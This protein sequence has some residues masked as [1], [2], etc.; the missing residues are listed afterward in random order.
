MGRWWV[1]WLRLHAQRIG[2]AT[3]VATLVAALVTGVLGGLRLLHARNLERRLVRAQ[4]LQNAVLE[5]QLAVARGGAARRRQASAAVAA[6]FGDLARADPAA[7]DALGHA[8]AS[9]ARRT[10]PS[11]SATRRLE[12]EIQ[13]ALARDARETLAVNPAARW[14][15]AAALATTFLLVIELG[16]QFELA[17]R[18]GRIDRDLAERANELARLRSS[19]VATVSHELRTP[20][21]SIVG[22]LELLDESA[23]G[24]LDATERATYL[25]SARRSAGRLA[26]LVDQ[27]LTLTEARRALLG[28]DVRTL[29]VDALVRETVTAARPAADAGSVEIRAEASNLGAIVGDPTRLGQVLDNLVSNAIKFTPGGGAVAVRARR[30]SGGVAF[31]VSDTGIGIS[32]DDRERL[33]EPFFRSDEATA[34]AVPGTGLG[35]TIAKAIVDAHRGEIAVTSVPGDGTTFRVWIPDEPR[36]VTDA[37]TDVAAVPVP[38]AG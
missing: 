29:D 23:S 28:L 20:L 33:F 12:A 8:Y 13:A 35:L 14:M 30:E 15:L 1:R 6:A 19:L 26:L 16:W 32:A 38:E 2:A 18:S 31:E 21:T 5:Q 11:S 3:I 24:P 22:Y 4:Q 27:L 37:A 36:P 25:A 17:R 10:A 9:F 7:A 34:A